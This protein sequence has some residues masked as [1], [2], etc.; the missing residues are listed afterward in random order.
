LSSNVNQRGRIDGTLSDYEFTM[1]GGETMKKY[2][3][4]E[5][6]AISLISAQVA[7]SAPK[8]IDFLTGDSRFDDARRLGYKAKTTYLVEAVKL[9]CSAA[10]RFRW[11]VQFEPD[12]NGIPS[13]L[14]YVRFSSDGRRYSMSWHTPLNKARTLREF[15]GKGEKTHWN[16]RL[17]ESFDGATELLRLLDAGEL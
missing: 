4:E 6:I 10:T 2:S 11:S 9:L 8:G 5:R 15:A 7:S 1:K 17:N 13:L 14:T 3:V 12:Q 16:G